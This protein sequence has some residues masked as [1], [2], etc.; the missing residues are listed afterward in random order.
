M[1]PVIVFLEVAPG[2][3][4][5]QLQSAFLVEPVLQPGS[6]LCLAIFHIC[7]AIVVVGR[8]YNVYSF[9]DGNGS[10]H[11]A[12]H[13]AYLAVL[14]PQP[15][16]SDADRTSFLLLGRCIHAT[17]PLG[18]YTIAIATIVIALTDSGIPRY[19]VFVYGMSTAFLSADHQSQF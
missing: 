6:S 8:G 4:I 7:I 1:Y 9:V 11:I 10:C 12:T 16:G 19:Y 18:T 15:F 5:L 13:T 2:P 3:G 14:T 17:L